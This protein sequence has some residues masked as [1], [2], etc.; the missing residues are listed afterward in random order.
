MATNDGIPIYYDFRPGLPGCITGMRATTC[1]QVGPF[2]ETLICAEDLDFT[3]RAF[4]IGAT[5][6][7]Q[8]DAVMHVRRP[9]NSR[10]AF[11]KSRSYGN[12]AVWIYERYRSE[13]LQ[14]RSLRKVLGP[15]RWMLANAY[16]DGGPW[17]WGIAWQAGTIYGRAE[18][19]IRRRVLYP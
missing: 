7:R 5:F 16:R 17:M 4:A 6:G 12:A 8:L 2:D 3:W 14:R 10:A 18:E 11:K 13:G 9:P 1:A 19:S 15:W